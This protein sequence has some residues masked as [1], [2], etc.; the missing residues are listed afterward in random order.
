MADE[1]ARASVAAVRALKEL[2]LD[3]S[4]HRSTPLSRDRVGDT[5][6][7]LAIDAELAHAARRRLGTDVP[8]QSLAEYVGAEEELPD[9]FIESTAVCRE[10]AERLL[11]LISRALF[12]L[13]Q[14]AREE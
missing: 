8:V 10:I 6:L 5:D 2:G 9:V 3:I 4:D 7:V 11:D 14:Q 1:G 13:E 12:R